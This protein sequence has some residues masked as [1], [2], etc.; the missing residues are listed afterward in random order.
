MDIV[1]RTIELEILLE[2]IVISQAGEGTTTAR[3]GQKARRQRGLLESYDFNFQEWSAPALT[4]QRSLQLS[5]HHGRVI[6][7]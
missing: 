1:R 2:Y 3:D 4:L 5:V 6:D 7:D